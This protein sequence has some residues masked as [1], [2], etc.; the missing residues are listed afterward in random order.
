MK[1][2]LLAVLVLGVCIVLSVL[3]AKSQRPGTDFHARWLAGRWFW[4]GQPLYQY[5]PGVRE[6]TYPPFA[7]MVFQ[8]FA[9]FP[10]KVAAGLFYFCNLLL[11]P[12][13]VWLTVDVF[14]TMWPPPERPRE[15]WRLAL[16]VLFSAQFFL[17]N[18]N[19]VQVNLAL[20]VLCLLGIRWYL[21]GHDVRGAAALVAATAIKLV[22]VFLVLWL[23]VRGRRRAALAVAPLGLACIALPM[24]QRGPTQG[25]QDFSDY[26][27]T[28]LEGFGKGRVE[29]RY[30][31][32]NLAA[33]VYRFTREPTEPTERDYRV[34]ATSEQTARIVYQIEAFVVVAAFGGTL[35]WL[36]ASGAPLSVF[37]VT[38]AFLVGHLLSA[39]TWKAH[40]VTLLF[41][42]YAFLSL[43]PR[44]FTWGILALMA[45][46]GLTGRDLVGDWAHHAI[47][48]Y[49]VIV[50]MMLFM[51][52][53]SLWLS[54]K[55]SPA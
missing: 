26:Y 12:V 38:A 19:L 1:R 37:E 47:G 3:E 50:W 27:H 44:G 30:T 23:M 48:G 9:L 54:R 6:P 21:A 51:L 41:G 31:N 36:R 33:S 2:R 5:L 35:L 42:Y 25:V 14:D 34:V 53:A 10:L 18:L 43:K 16:A 46:T 52:G 20:F 7:A 40:L 22:P 55:T 45:I 8:V 24:V 32:Q 28:L 13:A 39:M 15:P 49:S 11:I 17:N 29:Q 4:E